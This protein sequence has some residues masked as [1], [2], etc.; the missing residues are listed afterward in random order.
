M[1]DKN[2]NYILDP[3]YINRFNDGK[4]RTF[5]VINTSYNKKTGFMLLIDNDSNEFYKSKFIDNQFKD[6]K[7]MTK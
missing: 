7:K 6:I 1:F 2:R 3:W 5:S 4:Y